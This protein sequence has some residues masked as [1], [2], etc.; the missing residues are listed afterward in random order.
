MS[1]KEQKFHY[2]VVLD[3]SFM[4]II[5]VQ[6]GSKLYSKV[7]RMEGEEVVPFTPLEIIKKGCKFYASSYNG[8]KEGTKELIGVT[9]KAPIVIDPIQN[10]YFFP[11]ASPKQHHCLWISYSHVSTFK[12]LDRYHTEVVFITGESIEVPISYLSFE[13]QM[14]RTALLRTKID[15]HFVQQERRRHYYF[16]HFEYG[17]GAMERGYPY[18]LPPVHS[19][20]QSQ[21]STNLLNKK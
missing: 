17:L 5:P 8:R 4:A 9:H 2:D 10:I 7:I 6:Y 20:G 21:L 3:A 19:F 14:L 1:I 11:T 15:P 12:R 13:K 16:N 18:E